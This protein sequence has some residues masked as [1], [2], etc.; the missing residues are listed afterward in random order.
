[1]SGLSRRI[2]GLAA[3]INIKKETVKGTDVSGLKEA[4]RQIKAVGMANKYVPDVVEKINAVAYEA[5]IAERAIAD[6]AKAFSEL[7]PE[8][9]KMILRNDTDEWTAPENIWTGE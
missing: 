2:F 1:M 5:T 9:K 3:K 6:F 7:P 4:A 8:I